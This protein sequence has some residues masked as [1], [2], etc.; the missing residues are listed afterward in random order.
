MQ[1]L[2]Q[3]VTTVLVSMFFLSAQANAQVS[4]CSN[5]CQTT[6]SNVV[7]M[8]WGYYGW[9]VDQGTL[10]T[11]LTTEM[12]FNTSASGTTIQVHVQPIPAARTIHEVHGNVTLTVWPPASG[13]SC[14]TGT[15][16]AQVRD[17]SGNSVASVYLQDFT[18]GYGSSDDIPIKG[19][20][21]SGL[22]ITSF[23]F[24]SYSSQCGA[25]TLSWDLAMS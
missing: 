17:Q 10:T 25:L 23:Q 6:H 20:F 8:S 13:Q 2:R 7:Y 24:Q 4:T 22:S 15:L 18:A 21:P 12:G 1:S 16:I 3:K 11:R 9:Q 5:N 14:A 19:T